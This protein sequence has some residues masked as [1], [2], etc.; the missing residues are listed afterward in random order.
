MMVKVLK[1]VDPKK[2]KRKGIDDKET[3]ENRIELTKLYT[4]G[5]KR[6]AE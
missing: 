5:Q 3:S 2:G 1:K 4:D 6:N